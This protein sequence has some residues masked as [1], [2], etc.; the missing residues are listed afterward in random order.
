[1]YMYRIRPALRALLLTAIVLSTGSAG[2]SLAGR[3]RALAAATARE[4]A[5]L[6]TGAATSLSAELAFAVQGNVYILL[7]DSS[8]RQLTHGNNAALP[9]LSPNGHAVAYFLGS[10][11][12]QS[13]AIRGP[14]A[15]WIAPTSPGSSQAPYRLTSATVADA[16]A[17]AGL[18]WSPDSRLLAYFQGN[19]LVVH[20]LARGSSPIVLRQP[21]GTRFYGWHVAS[22]SPNSRSLVA[23]LYP[24]KQ[25]AP[26]RLDAEV[27]ALPD[28][29]GTRI[30]ASLPP[31]S[32][33]SRNGNIPVSV[34]NGDVTWM[35]DGR[36]FR[37]STII[38]GAGF[39]Q[40]TGMWEASARGGLARL[41]TG[42]PDTVRHGVLPTGSPLDGASH[43]TYSPDRTMLATD[44]R[45]GLWVSTASGTR[46]RALPVTMPRGCVMAQYAWLNDGTGL[47]YLRVCAVSGPTAGERQS[48]LFVASLSDASSRILL[49]KTSIDYAVIDIGEA[50]RCVLCGG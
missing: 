26:L 33:G 12:A 37:F 39:A 7:P 6:S 14:F 49:Q 15:V 48:T 10:R 43:W 45:E 32:L 41:V 28:S 1:M 13:G 34:V 22:W 30:T 47:A 42:T 3:A 20:A 44:P 24:L 8:T 2:T 29:R 38:L 5:Q 35:P 17:G 36:D 50:Y 16:Q 25:T 23:A 4:P 31:G 40:L 9:A 21:G 19:T 18:A 11:D 27:Y 46:G